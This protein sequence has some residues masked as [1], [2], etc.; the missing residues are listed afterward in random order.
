MVCTSARREGSEIWKKRELGSSKRRRSVDRQRVGTHIN[1][2]VVLKPTSVQVSRDWR[3][4]MTTPSVGVSRATASDS[5]R[6][7]NI[8]AM[9]VK[10]C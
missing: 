1:A 8:C 6:K 10:F 2:S 9:L 3:Y 7:E 5:G 4:C